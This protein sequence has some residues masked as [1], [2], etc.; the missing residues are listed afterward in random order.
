VAGL[1]S[2]VPERAA[3]GAWTPAKSSCRPK[4]AVPV[5]TFH[6]L[7]DTTNPYSG[8]D[9]PRWGYGVEEALARWARLDRCKR[10]PNTTTATPTVSLLLYSKC[11]DGATVGLYREQLAGHTWPGSAGPPDGTTDESIDATALIWKFFRRHSLAE[12]D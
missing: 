9:D 10:G 2:G 7:A 5:R 8:N 4:Q 1:R 6:G 11:R 12:R 3:S